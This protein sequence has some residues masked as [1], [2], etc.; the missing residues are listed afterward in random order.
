[1]S[2]NDMDGS[3]EFKTNLS[4]S[5]QA[6]RVS[7]IP[8]RDFTFPTSGH[9]LNPEVNDQSVRLRDE[10]VAKG[11]LLMTICWQY[12]NTMSKSNFMNAGSRVAAD[13]G[14]SK[15]LNKAS[16]ISEAIARSGS[17]SV[18]QTRRR[19]VIHTF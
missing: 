9:L 11:R 6:H 18:A 17:E 15:H 1:M 2:E 13:P 10:A 19:D 12:Y 8:G 14:P 5:V 3:E 16:I 7:R 4:V